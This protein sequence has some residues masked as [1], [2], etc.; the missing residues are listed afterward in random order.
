MSIKKTRD[1]QI[2]LGLTCKILCTISVPFIHPTLI[3]LFGKEICEDAK[4]TEDDITE[5]YIQIPPV[6]RIPF[7]NDIEKLIMNS[8]DTQQT[9]RLFYLSFFPQ[10]TIKRLF[11]DL[12]AP[13]T[14]MVV[15]KLNNGVQRNKGNARI[16]LLEWISELIKWEY[17]DR[18]K[19]MKAVCRLPCYFKQGLESRVYMGF[20]FTN[21]QWRGRY[22]ELLRP[23]VRTSKLP[24]IFKGARY[25][26]AMFVEVLK[27]EIRLEQIP[28]YIRNKTLVSFSAALKLS[29]NYTVMDKWCMFLASQTPFF[30][31]IHL[32][33]RWY[34]T[35]KQIENLKEN[36]SGS[37]YLLKPELYIQEVINKY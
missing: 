15:V 25:D 19:I 17:E 3:G 26:I 12:L 32:V 4:M 14:L 18:F 5:C 8:S 13:E 6:I 9:S 22:W 7:F 28:D 33:F 31:S 24:S 35:P 36:L 2:T 11:S 23:I 29:E 27:D 20:T 1:F 16:I 34:L 21:E 10:Q 30:D 37:Y